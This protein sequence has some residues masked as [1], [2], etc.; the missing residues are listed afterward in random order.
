[1]DLNSSLEQGSDT[2]LSKKLQGIVM[3]SNISQNSP[4]KKLNPSRTLFVI[5]MK[6]N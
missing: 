3:Q 5:D 1:M 6:R 4:K 2:M